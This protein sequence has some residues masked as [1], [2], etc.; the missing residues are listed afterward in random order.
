MQ[1]KA[2]MACAAFA[3]ELR[4]ILDFDELSRSRAKRD[5]RGNTSGGKFIGKFSLILLNIIRFTIQQPQALK[6]L[7]NPV[8]AI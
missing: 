5:F 2:F 6:V 8:I 3:C 1:A 7:N 4:L